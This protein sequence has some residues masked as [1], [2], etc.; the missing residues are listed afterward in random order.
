MS[1]I[2][3]SEELTK[4]V[5]EDF[6]AGL[7]CSQVTFAYAAKKLGFDEKT[8]KKIGAGF[9]GGMFNGER[10]GAVTGALMGL[11]LA[12]GHS[13]KEDKPNEARLQAKKGELEKQFLE[14]YNSL[15]CEDIIGANIGT[16]EGQA[17]MKEGNLFAGCPALTAYVCQILDELIPDKE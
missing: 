13:S 11:G 1:T 16:P 8:A 10:C 9:G 14:K 3:V 15:L 7:H 12:Y 4:K 6:A 2:T 17:K 5:A